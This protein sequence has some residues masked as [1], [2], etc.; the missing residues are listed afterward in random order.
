MFRC[1]DFGIPIVYRANAVKRTEMNLN[2]NLNTYYCCF[3]FIKLLLTV[4]I[5]L[6]FLDH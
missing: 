1:Q 5:Q 2:F 4:P 6:V 3:S